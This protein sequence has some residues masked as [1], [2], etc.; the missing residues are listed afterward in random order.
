MSGESFC[1][2]T[3]LQSDYRTT[4]CPPQFNLVDSLDFSLTCPVDLPCPPPRPAWLLGGAGGPRSRTLAACGSRR[5]N[6]WLA[7][8]QHAATTS[9]SKHVSKISTHALFDVI[10]HACSLDRSSW[11]RDLALQPLTRAFQV[12][13]N[14][15]DIDALV[16]RLCTLGAP[17]DPR[18]ATNIK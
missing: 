7:C 18:Q 12:F 14:M 5:R 17:R 13:S 16:F 8:L 10:H 4:S 1:T 2:L 3:E 9:C 15:V 6:A 11:L